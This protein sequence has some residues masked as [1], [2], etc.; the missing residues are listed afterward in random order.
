MKLKQIKKDKLDG[1]AQFGL[2]EFIVK[3]YSE[4]ETAKQYSQIDN[5]GL[6]NELADRLD[7]IS[8]SLYEYVKFQ[9]EYLQYV[10]YYNPKVADYYYIVVD[11]KVFKDETKPHLVLRNIKTG[12]EIKTRIKQ[13][14]IFKQ[15]PF[16]EFSVLRIDRFTIGHKKKPINGKWIETDEEE[17]ILDEYEV[18]KSSSGVM[19]GDK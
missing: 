16:G 6:L 3:K 13:S 12:N 7:N 17:F 9:K 18:I 19:W 2:T 11:F 4:K 5:Y 1:Y 14:K 15:N 10:T 8:M